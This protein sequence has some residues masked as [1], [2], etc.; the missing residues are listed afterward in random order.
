MRL[1][2]AILCG[3]SPLSR[4]ERELIAA[5]VSRGHHCSFSENTHGSC[6]ARALDGGSGAVA[7][8]LDSVDESPFGPKMRSLLRLAE[9]VRLGGATT[10][11]CR[12]SISGATSD[13]SRST[14]AY[15]FKSCSCRCRRQGTKA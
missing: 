9:K 15:E 1:A 6:A 11:S 2:D 14:P 5:G 7:L 4:G 13:F 8:T 3:P 10:R 12:N